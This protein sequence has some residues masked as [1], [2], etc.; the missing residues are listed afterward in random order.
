MKQYAIQITDKALGDMDAST[1]ILPISFR[2]RKML[3]DN[4]IGL[5][6]QYKN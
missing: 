3:W 2:R 1:T 6:M 5:Q 4:I